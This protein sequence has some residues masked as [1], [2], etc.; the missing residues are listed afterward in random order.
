MIPTLSELELLARQAGDILRRGYGLRHQVDNK[1]VI[2]LV[3]EVDRQSEAFLLGEIRRRFPGHRILAEESGSQA[4]DDCC[5]WLI[6][7]L[8]GTV[9]YA[10]GV[11]VFSVSIALQVDGALRL[12][13]VFDPLRDECFSAENGKGAW[14]NREPIHVAQARELGTSLLVT[15]FPYDIRENPEN[16]LD[17]YARFSLVTQGVRRLGSAALDLSYVA[18]GRFDGYWELRLSPWDVAAGAL[19]AAEAG[20]V[21]SDVAGGPDYLP[22]A[23]S[24]LAANPLIHEQMMAILQRGD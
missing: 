14:L 11:P 2:D 19:I 7:P 1:G 5:L 4:G 22:N 10:H 23:D 18:C 24:I 9:N 12:G 20:A 6:D 8:D 16:N 3:T 21:V 13:V 17:H 15:G